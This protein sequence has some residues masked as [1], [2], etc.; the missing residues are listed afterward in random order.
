MWRWGASFSIS[1]RLNMSRAR[2]IL[3]LPSSG[4][5]EMELNMTVPWRWSVHLGLSGQHRP[6]YPAGGSA[7]AAHGSTISQ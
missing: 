1:F 2:I 7:R 6:E 4:W 3:Q 5:S